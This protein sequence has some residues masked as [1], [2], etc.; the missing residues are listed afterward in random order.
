[1]RNG[2]EPCTS[3]YGSFAGTEAARFGVSLTFSGL[4][5]FGRKAAYK[6]WFAPAAGMAAFNGYW[7]YRQAHTQLGEGEEKVHPSRARK[8]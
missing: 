8:F 7:A 3:H 1:V 6:E 2:V 5:M 4:S